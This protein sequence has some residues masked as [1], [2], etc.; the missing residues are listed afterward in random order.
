MAH[1]F[2]L[3]NREDLSVG[4]LLASYKIMSNQAFDK[5]N[6]AILFNH[7]YVIG[8]VLG[9]EVWGMPDH[10][11]EFG[12]TAATAA[13][14]LAILESPEAEQYFKEVEHQIQLNRR[15]GNESVGA[16]I[17]AQL[18]PASILTLMKFAYDLWKMFKELRKPKK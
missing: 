17:N 4:M 18:N 12:A 7:A 10:N 16:E 11:H 1:Y 14:E 15:F 3:P 8:G 2:E 9:R 13:T 6:N 5:N